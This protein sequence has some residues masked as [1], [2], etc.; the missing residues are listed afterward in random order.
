M[1]WNPAPTSSSIESISGSVNSLS[2]AKT[3]YGVMKSVSIVWA[4]RRRFLTSA[5]EIALPVLHSPMTT[6]VFGT[7]MRSKIKSVSHSSFLEKTHLLAPSVTE[8]VLNSMLI[9][10]CSVRL[11]EIAPASFSGISKI[12]DFANLQALSCP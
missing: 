2:F 9:S 1:L 6:R 8:R 5:R 7:P 12:P 10:C 3:I 11:T 4:T